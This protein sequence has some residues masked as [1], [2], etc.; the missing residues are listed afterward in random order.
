[1]RINIKFWGW[2]A[3]GFLLFCVIYQV[4]P[5]VLFK[6]TEWQRIFNLE[7]SSSL[8]ELEKN[9]GKAGV[10]LVYISFL[11]GVFHAIGPGHGKFIL[12]SYLAIEK[13]KLFQA[14]K[15]SFIS[16]FVQGVVAVL[17]VTTIVAIFTLSRQYFNL[18]LKWVERGSFTIM[19]LFGSYWCYQVFKKTSNK[20]KLKIKSI[21]FSQKTDEKL[22]LVSLPHIHG[23]NCGCGHKHLPTFDEMKKLQDWKA[24]LMTILSIGTRPCSGAILVLFLSYTLNLYMWGVFSA[25]M[26]AIGTGLT[27]SL[28]AYFVVA[29]RDRAVKMSYWYLSIETNRKLVRFLKLTAGV[30]LI[31]LGVA[32][33]HSSMIAPSS[34]IF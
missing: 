9:Q 23:K 14:L 12:T 34:K 7:L 29:A 5:V 17:L 24:E 27:L 25:L 32:L 21:S 31:L 22:P 16:A 10:T 4:Y 30:I 28:F 2:I 1:M 8:R 18:T 26:M 15:I 6:V 11:Y 19:I 20:Q 33:F 13:T 3:V